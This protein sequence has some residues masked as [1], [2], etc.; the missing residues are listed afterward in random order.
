[1]TS[2][3][4]VQIRNKKDK[5]L[6]NEG[7]IPGIIYGAGKE[8]VMIAI[9]EKEL[10]K[11]CSEL[12]FSRTVFELNI[13]S[14]IEKVL[15]KE[16]SYHPVTG[17]I[18]HVDFLRVSKGTK[19]K[20]QIPIEVINEDKSPGL[21]KGGLVNLVVHRL[22]CFVASESIPDKIEL[23]LTGKEIGESFLL[24][25]INLPNGLTAVNPERDAV[26]A[27][28]V[29]SKIESEETVTQNTETTTENKENPQ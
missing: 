9:Q 11:E 5:K 25:N 4:V 15:P 17:K 3:L 29:T 22:E 13:N 2:G 23:D 16:V 7:Y 6:R 20:V 19:I 26:L 28:I 1:M 24:N 14:K 18:L 10:V 21:K 12:A 8:P 27:T